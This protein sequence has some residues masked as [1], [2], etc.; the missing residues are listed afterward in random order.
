MNVIF[1]WHKTALMTM[2]VFRYVMSVIIH[3]LFQMVNMVCI[4]YNTLGN[5]RGELMPVPL[6][7]I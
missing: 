5:P 4:H 3:D 2:R 1:M 7:R 6:H